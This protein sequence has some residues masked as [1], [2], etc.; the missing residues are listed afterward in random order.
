LE[1]VL[2]LLLRAQAEVAAASREGR[3]P[4]P[5]FVIL[6]EMNLAHVEQYFSDFLSCLESGEMLDLHREPELEAG[7]DESEIAVP[8]RLGIP[9]N[10]FFTGTVNVDET[11]YMFSPKVLDRA[12]TIEL[13]SVDLQG[14]GQ[15]STSSND[16]AG[17]LRLRTMPELDEP[18]KPDTADWKAFSALDGGRFQSPVVA[19][20]DLLAPYTLHFGYRVA[21][22]IARFVLLAASHT[23]GTAQSILAALDLAI[24]EKVLPK[25]HGTQE[26]LDEPLRA[27]FTFAVSGAAVTPP[28]SWEKIRDSWRLHNDRLE[29]T[30][31]E[32]SELKLPR[33]ATKIW[34][35]LR[36]LHQQGFTAFIS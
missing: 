4:F 22:E 3:R 31:G 7:E 26:E 21:N 34:L 13:H 23:D 36:R 5:F 19:L 10:V 2:E 18:K 16:R 15:S 30:K 11:T 24:L 1:P 32:P 27:L 17:A 12:F 35:M 29:P 25:F 33:T 14:Y 28:S 9:T 6:D 8:T 20:N